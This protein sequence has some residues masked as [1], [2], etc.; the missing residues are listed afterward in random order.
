MHK[1]KI[2]LNILEEDRLEKILYEATSVQSV[3]RYRLDK[4]NLE[5]VYDQSY[6]YTKDNDDIK[7]SQRFFDISQLLN[8]RGNSYCIDNINYIYCQEDDSHEISKSFFKELKYQNI[9]GKDIETCYKYVITKYQDDILSLSIIYNNLKDEYNL[10]LVTNKEIDLL[11]IHSYIS[12][13]INV[14][15]NIDINLTN[16]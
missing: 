15:I 5:Q 12:D 9:C 6:F 4:Y 2:K 13:N 7:V 8:I 10:E 11:K 16:L 14:K 3:I 1:I